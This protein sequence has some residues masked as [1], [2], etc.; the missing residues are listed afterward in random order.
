MSMPPEASAP[1]LMVSRP[2]RIGSRLRAHD[3]RKAERRRRRGRARRLDE[4]S[5]IESHFASSTIGKSASIIEYGDGRLASGSSRSRR[6]RFV[7]G[8]IDTIL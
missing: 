1:V 7:P 5:A 8:T 4:L 2:I 6:T 3:G